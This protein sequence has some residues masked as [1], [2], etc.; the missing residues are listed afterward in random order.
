[1]PEVDL[2][3]LFEARL[4]LV[5]DNPTNLLFLSKLLRKSGWTNVQTSLVPEEAEEMALAGQPDLAV[6][7][8]HMPGIGGFGLLERLR[9]QTCHQGYLPILVF[10]ADATGEARRRALDLGATD[11]LTKPGDPSEIVL[12]VRNFLQMRLLY[13]KLEEH[14]AQLESRVLERTRRLEEA[15]MEIVHRLALAGDYRDDETGEHCRRVSELSYRIALAYGLSEDE[16]DLIR[17]ASPLHDIG[18]VAISDAILK[19]PGRLSDGEFSEMQRHVQIG[20][21]ILA[22]SS[23]EV[24]KVAHVIAMSHHERWDGTGYGVGL[25]GDAIPVSGRI[26]AVADVFDALT[27]ERPYKRRW[28]VADAVREI[29]RCSGTHFDPAVVA[30]F[31]RAVETFEDERLAA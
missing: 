22:G 19:K 21:S 8:L 15:Q 6:I 16:A 27:S 23:S 9:A 14:N 2:D 10:T 20:A 30:A 17:L 7:D 1:M 3:G 12:R 4:L 31:R 5:D 18:K 26:V 28:P 13:R 29:E 25:R 11:F 24:L